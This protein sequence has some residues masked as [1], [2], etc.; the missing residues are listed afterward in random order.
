MRDR[1]RKFI[2]FPGMSPVA[3]LCLGALLLSPAGCSGSGEEAP[4]RP[5]RAKPP[6]CVIDIDKTIT[7]PA[8]RRKMAKKV[9]M[10]NAPAVLSRVASRGIAVFYL[11]RRPV[12]RLEATKWWLAQHGFPP[13]AG[14]YLCDRNEDRVPFKIRIIQE[15]QE[16]YTFLFGVGDQP[17]DAESYGICGI[18]YLHIET[19]ADWL[20]AER[21]IEEIVAAASAGRPAGRGPGEAEFAAEGRNPYFNLEP[22]SQTVLEGGGGKLT[23]TVLDETGDFAGIPARAVEEREEADGRISRTARSYYTIC[24]DTNDVFT[25]GPKTNAGP[26][27]A[28]IP[29]RSLHASLFLPGQPRRGMRYFREEPSGTAG[30]PV[31][32]RG[33]SMGE[34]VVTP[35]GAFTGCLIIRRRPQPDGGRDEILAFAPGIGLVRKD[36][37]LL[38]RRPGPS[39]APP[40]RSLPRSPTP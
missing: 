20:D 33:L 34:T 32:I 13:G 8:F 30:E 21:R 15:L 24:A 38:V 27:G 35:A 22:G 40:P 16:N 39:G 25:L 10:A 5:P 12:G 9:P 7:D 6:A 29:D 23:I 19:A 37:L 18:P 2:A 3:A 36:D 26:G 1:R 28:A 31:E 14:L 11:S 17:T 4:A